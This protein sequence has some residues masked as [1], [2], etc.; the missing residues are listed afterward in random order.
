VIT[1]GADTA[2]AVTTLGADTADAVTTL[3][4]DMMLAACVTMGADLGAET[5]LAGCDT[6]GAACATVL[7][8]DEMIFGCPSVD[9]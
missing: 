8:V 4:A 7:R 3:G 9:V 1:L 2:D 5:I 6:T